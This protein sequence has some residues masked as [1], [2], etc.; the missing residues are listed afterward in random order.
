[1]HFEGRN[2][3]HIDSEH[4]TVRKRVILVVFHINMALIIAVG[5]KDTEC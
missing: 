2:Y 4:W 3:G 5:Q 1:M